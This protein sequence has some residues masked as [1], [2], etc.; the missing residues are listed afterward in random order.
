MPVYAYD[1][2]LGIEGLK[3]G[4]HKVGELIVQGMKDA[5]IFT[6]ARRAMWEASVAVNAPRTAI[7]SAIYRKQRLDMVFAEDPYNVELMMSAVKLL[8]LDPAGECVRGG[9]C[10]DN[11]IVLASALMSVGIPVRLVIR[12]YKHMG[13]LHLMLEYDAD[14]LNRGRWT[15]FDATSPD[16][17]CF[18]GYESEAV[19]S[20]EVG[21]M[22]V[23]KQPPQLLVLGRPP[24]FGAPLAASSS[25]S[26]T[27]TSS[28][29]QL[30][31]D[32]AD[33]WVALLAAAKT[34][35]DASLDRLNFFT[36]QIEAVRSDLGM[37]D[38]DPT[39]PPEAPGAGS[40]S[41]SPIDVYATGGYAWTSDVQNAQAKLSQTG[42]FLSGVLGDALAGTRQL[43]WNEGDLFVTAVDGDPYGV[44]M[45]P[46][47]A[48][49]TA[50]FPT[51]VDVQSGAAT[52]KVGFGI[53]PILIGLGIVVASLAA[54]YAVVK[55]VDY[56]ASAHRDDAVSKI[57]AAQQALVESGKQTPEQAAAFM[58]ASADLVSAPPP[59][60]AASSGISI[61][62][63]VA[64][65]A[66]GALAGVIGAE[67]VPKLLSA[68]LSFAPAPA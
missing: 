13:Q 46:I 1:Y 17:T 30:P 38:V 2:S 5:R 33:A 20:L 54:V 15:C 61:G 60:A 37:P 40:S 58:K 57:A 26:T 66:G 34:K 6:W 62:W 50:L 18:T 16:G 22:I 42:T 68:R 65:V 41:Q 19:I 49:G 51:Y 7:V 55:I 10:D 44:L 63:L 47:G 67:L 9:D 59:S 36:G 48:A 45:K 39:P 53:A 56:L 28:S 43:Y 29:A 32:Q 4:V 14:P 27:T 8:C 31:P 23:D 11:V 24:F 21:P 25:T 3:E 35:L 64:A 12:H 52:G